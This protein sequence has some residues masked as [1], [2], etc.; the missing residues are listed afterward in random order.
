MSDQIDSFWFALNDKI[1]AKSDSRRELWKIKTAYS[2]DYRKYHNLKHI[3]RGLQELNEVKGLSSESYLRIAYAY[4]FHDIEKTKEQ[5]ANTALTAMDNAKLPVSFKTQVVYL[6]LVTKHSVTV[7]ENYLDGQLIKDIDLSI[8]GQPPD[9]FDEYETQIAE[10][11]SWI[12]PP[13]L[14]IQKRLAVLDNLI[15]RRHLFL[16]PHFQ[17]KYEV[18][19]RL[20][21]IRSIIRLTGVHKVRK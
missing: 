17:T 3:E 18:Q 6:I 21:L 19:A 16:T 8:L 14:Y 2:Q 15:R 11:F 10:E 9:V 20:N 1:G 12:K 13:E 4:F 7:E 5:S